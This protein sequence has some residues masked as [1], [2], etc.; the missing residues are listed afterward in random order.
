MECLYASKVAT[1]RRHL[2]NSMLGSG[3]NPVSG[4]HFSALLFV[5]TLRFMKSE[6]L[7]GLAA[8]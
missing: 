2:K 6:G 5:L 7:L 3:K 8:P 1:L 4:I